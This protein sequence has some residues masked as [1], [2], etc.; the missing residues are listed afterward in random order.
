MNLFKALI[1]SWIEL[2]HEFHI[3]NDNVEM[4]EKTWCANMGLFSITDDGEIVFHW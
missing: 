3:M 4:F 2:E 1:E